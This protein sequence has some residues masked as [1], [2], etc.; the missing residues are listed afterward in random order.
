MISHFRAR[1]HICS[2]IHG[3]DAGRHP[4]LRGKFALQLPR[5]AKA[6]PKSPSGRVHIRAHDRRA[7]SSQ[8]PMCL[9]LPTPS[10]P[11]PCSHT[12][13]AGEPCP[14]HASSQAC[15]MPTCPLRP[16]PP[17]PQALSLRLRPCAHAPM[18]VD[19]PSLSLPTCPLRPAPP[20]PQA[21]L[22]FCLR[23]TPHPP[24]ML[25]CT[26]QAHELNTT[27]QHE[28][29]GQGLVTIGSHDYLRCMR[30]NSQCREHGHGWLHV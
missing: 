10:T 22:T 30:G 21:H 6:C 8:T 17:P 16:A 9:R 13:S 29:H 14:A 26:M 2:L 4:F 25:L 7:P 24:S 28:Y 15:P 27:E 1:H 19:L 3:A 11:A 18:R 12:L 5:P 23:T 20:P